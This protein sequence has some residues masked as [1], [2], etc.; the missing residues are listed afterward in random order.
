M[1]ALFQSRKF[2]LILI[3]GVFVIAGGAVAFFIGDA[4]WQKFIVFL[5]ASL[6]PIFVAAVVGIY[7]EDV[8]AL[9]AGVHP[10]QLFSPESETEG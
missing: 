9:H 10:N 7:Q 6:Q 8:A 3:D 2:L 5:L 4:D 1:K